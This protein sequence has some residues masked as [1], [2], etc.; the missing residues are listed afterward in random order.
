MVKASVL[1]V[2]DENIVAED[3]S[4]CL[5]SAGYTVVG[6]SASG[7]DALVKTETYRP[8]LVC[9]DIVLAGKLN[10]IQ[11]ADRII[12]NYNI[13]VIYLT[14]YTDEDTIEKAKITDPYGYIVKP[15]DDKV[16][17]RTLDMALYKHRLQQK[18]RESEEKYRLLIE[19]SPLGVTIFQN[20]HLVFVNSALCD[21]LGY[22]D[23][24]LI[25]LSKQE[26]K[27]LIHSDDN[28]QVCHHLQNC[29]HEFKSVSA[30]AIRVFHKD[31]ELRWFELN[32]NYVTFNKQAAVYMTILNITEKKHLEERLYHSQKIET[33]GQLSAGIAHQLNTPLAVM[34]SRL[35]ILES[36]FERE[37]RT[38]FLHE[39]KKIMESLNKISNIITSLLNFSRQSIDKKENININMLVSELLTFVE[40]NAKKRNIQLET[41]LAKKLPEVQIVRN[42]V[43]QVFLNVIANA[44][45]AM[46]DGGIL[47]VR[48]QLI[49][50]EQG[51]YA[52]ITFTDSGTGMTKKT[53]KNVFEPFF[54]TKPAGAGT[55]LG[56]FLSYNIIKEHNG[57]ID[58]K[59]ARGKGTSFQILIPVST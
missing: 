6:C 15:F 13:P 2:E 55:G 36:D 26:L 57:A 34:S 51:S 8:D 48:S 17:L 18:L 35:Q 29:L 16:L 33:I 3:I 24:Q 22:T 45:D 21:M 10:G 58:I 1:V 12:R 49:K 5:K 11:T 9:M 53:Q 30:Y 42:K 23:R 39:T 28:E 46:P 40:V 4:A 37:G 20:G 14:A 32:I 41:F 47:N 27:K 54:T 52:A 56:L 43:E 25:G 38:A 19:N 7:E 44:F 59:S 31:K 50:K